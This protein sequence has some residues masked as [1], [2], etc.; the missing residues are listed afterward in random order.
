MS[1]IENSKGF[2]IKLKF[3]CEDIPHST[4]RNTNVNVEYNSGIRQPFVVKCY[5]EIY[6]ATTFFNGDKPVV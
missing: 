3:L 4:R 6:E 2:L 5:A 1:Y